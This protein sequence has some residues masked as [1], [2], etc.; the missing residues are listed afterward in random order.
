MDPGL[1]RGHG[2]KHR[3]QLPMSRKKGHRKQSPA[4][5]RPS[6]SWTVNGPLVQ[7]SPT[8]WADTGVQIV[9]G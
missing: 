7:L 3:G 1:R 5:C 9:A 8:V 6:S 4:Y 2:S